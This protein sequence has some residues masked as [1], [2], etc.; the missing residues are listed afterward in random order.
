MP[1]SSSSSRG[2]PSSSVTAWRQSIGF[3]VLQARRL[4]PA[5][6]LGVVFFHLRPRKVMCCRISFCNSFSR[7]ARDDL[8]QPMKV[9]ALEGAWSRFQSPSIFQ[10]VPKPR[11]SASLCPNVCFCKHDP[12]DIAACAHAH[13]STQVLSESPRGINV[14]TCD[15]SLDQYGFQPTTLWVGH[16][17]IAPDTQTRR[18]YIHLLVLK[19]TY[20]YTYTNTYSYTFT[21]LYIC[22]YLYIY[23]F[24]YIFKNLPTYGYH[25]I[26]RFTKET[27]GSSPFSVWE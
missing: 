4:S 22:K 26:Q 27:S 17:K 15:D 23:I 6:R 2:W 19:K 12:W 21:Y 5:F 10:Q 3:L 25:V 9:N 18:E 7:E 8:T 13:R 1:D 24:I 16:Q 11:N 14:S 20:A